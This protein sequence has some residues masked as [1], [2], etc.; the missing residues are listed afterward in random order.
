MN[1]R[2]STITAEDIDVDMCVGDY[3]SSYTRKTYVL[4][5][6]DMAMT[7]DTLFLKTE[8][9]AKMCAGLWE[10]GAFE[11]GEYGEVNFDKAFV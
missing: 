9:A 5:L 11:R 2:T 7:V 3:D 6:F 4:E 1:F 8:T 10:E